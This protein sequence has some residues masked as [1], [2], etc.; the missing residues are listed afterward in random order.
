VAWNTLVARTTLLA[1]NTFGY[2]FVGLEHLGGLDHFVGYSFV[3]LE[4]LGGLDHFV[5]YS[6]VGDTSQTYL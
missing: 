1:W 4:H 2:S 5:G 3:G 6:W